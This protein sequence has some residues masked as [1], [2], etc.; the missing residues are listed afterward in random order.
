MCKVM[1][2]DCEHGLVD[3]ENALLRALGTGDP[4]VQA[5]SNIHV[6]TVALLI[7]NYRRSHRAS[8]TA[9]RVAEECGDTVNVYRALGLRAWAESRLGQ[10]PVA[11]SSLLRMKQLGQQLGSRPLYSDW[12]AAAEAEMALSRGRPAEARSL[13]RAAVD[14]ARAVGGLFAEGLAQRTWGQALAASEPSARGDVDVH[15]AESLRCFEEGGVAL[16][17]ARTRLVWARLCRER[18]DIVGAR[19][20]A[21]RAIALFEGFR[22]AEELDHARSVRDQLP[23]GSRSNRDGE[24]PA[25]SPAGLTAREREVLRLIAA[26]RTNQEIADALVISRPTAPRRSRSL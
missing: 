1:T 10:V 4:R 25:G 15:L 11:I 24:T 5:I 3:Q 2:G 12:Y 13:A 18:G 17:A 6:A 8:Q 23:R 22:L 20:H 19:A 21:D 26:G 9:A 7:G 14:Y 16:E